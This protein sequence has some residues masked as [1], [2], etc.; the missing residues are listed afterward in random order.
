MDKR[1]ALATILVNA[2]G[3]CRGVRVDKMDLSPWVT[4][5]RIVMKPNDVTRLMLEIIVQD[6]ETI[7][8]P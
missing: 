3:V 2:S 6:I 5:A 1:F 7:V 8:V 4:E